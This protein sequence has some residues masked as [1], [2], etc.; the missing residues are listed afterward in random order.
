[1]K[2]SIFS[3]C[4]YFVS[5]PPKHQ[6]SDSSSS[7]TTGERGCGSGQKQHAILPCAQVL[8]TDGRSDA[9]YHKCL[10]N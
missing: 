2:E 8:Y 9:T 10:D 7:V 1:M 4:D 5:D 6:H 3:S